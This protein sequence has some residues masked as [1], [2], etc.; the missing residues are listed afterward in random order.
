MGGGG[1]AGKI[2]HAAYLEEIHGQFLSHEN[3]DLP[4]KSITDVFNETLP[5]NPFLGETVISPDEQLA[6]ARTEYNALRVLVDA[7]DPVDNYTTFIL[8][9]EQSVDA[10]INTDFI[11]DPVPVFT[12]DESRIADS[13]AAFTATTN[14]TIDNLLLPPYKA[15]MHNINAVTSSA[16]IIGEAVIRGM[17]QHDV[18]RFSADL[19]TKFAEQS[20][21]ANAKL[22]IQRQD[23]ITKFNIQRNEFIRVVCGE[24][25]QELLRKT[26]LMYNTVHLN[27]QTVQIN[28]AA[29]NEE[30]DDQLTIDESSAK[31]ELELFQPVANLIAAPAGGISPGPKRP[32]KGVRVASGAVSGAAA[33]AATG[34][35]IGSAYAGYGA[36]IGAALGAGLALASG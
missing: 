26:D 20:N 1:S 12:P 29:K 2:E 17:S 9:A 35:A 10:V 5:N 24:M 33:G 27:L 22:L 36:I 7:L 19:Y 31:W 13:V 3:A 23:S 16:F 30:K 6:I 21:D 15:G 34:A 28:I 14:D 18:S 25:I 32:S 8:S 4:V 11:T